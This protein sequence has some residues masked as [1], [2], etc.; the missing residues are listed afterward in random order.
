[1]KKVLCFIFVLTLGSIHSSI[2]L[3]ADK[4]IDAALYQQVLFADEF[5]GEALDKR[6][7]MYKSAS[8]VRDGVMVGITPEDAGH[9]SVNTIYFT[10]QA[11][12]EMRVSFKFN[13]SKQ[14]SV[15][16]R[17]KVYKGTYFS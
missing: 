16:F 3:A 8:T 6:W 5:S 15:M 11:D 7:G 12:L 1:M 4:E 14:F 10:A 2:L 13:G 9:P 17:D